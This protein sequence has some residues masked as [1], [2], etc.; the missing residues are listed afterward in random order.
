MGFFNSFQF[1]TQEFNQGSDSFWAK[2]DQK[3]DTVPLVKVEYIATD[4]TIY[5]LSR[6]YDSG[7]VVDR[8]KERAPAEIQ[9]GDFDVTLFNHDDYF[10]EFVP[11]SLL[12]NATYHGSQI[13]VSLGFLLD[14]GSTY[15]VPQMT[16]LIDALITSD[17]ESKVTF[18]CRDLVQRILDT[19]LHPRQLLE[20]PVAGNN[21]GNGTCSAVESKPFKT[22]NESWTL[23][24]TTGG[25][26]GIAIFS[27]VG[28]VSGALSSLTSGTQY[29]TLAA[30]GGIR[31]LVS[32]GATA[33]A[34]G[35]SF[36]FSTY[37]HPEWSAVNIGK[38]IW[39]V[40]TGYNWDT[41]TQE[42]WANSV[43]GLDHTQGDANPD[44]NYASFALA[45]SQIPDSVTGYIDYEEDTVEF[46]K[47][48]LLMFL[49]SI[50]TDADGKLFV[51]MYQPQWQVSQ[52]SYSDAKKITRLGYQR[53]IDE[54]INY[55]NIHFKASNVWEFTNDEINY[56]GIF[57]DLDSGSIAKYGQL[58]F[59]Y[60]LRWYESG[61]SHVAT[62]VLQLLTK[63][64]EPPLDI[65]LT[66]GLDG[67]VTQLGDII[68]VTDTKYNLSGVLAE[69]T[70]LTKDLDAGP[71]EVR[72]R[73]VRD[74]TI[75]LMYG[76]LG[77]SVDEGDGISPQ[78]ATYGSATDVDKA[79]CYLGP[80]SDA[81]PNYY[82]F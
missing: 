60:S 72:I 47:G 7:A 39:A 58:P 56:D 50:F 59:T 52:R 23:T 1:N 15:Y 11:S 8:I 65:D 70:R 4:G 63:Y 45:I 30:A 31:L 10:S 61:N 81:A 6:Y 62:V 54:V 18:R 29:S 36:T 40:L 69:V 17:V 37:Q 77:S 51:K 74:A 66:T 33:W 80:D 71:K 46:L 57:I 12:Y 64:N 68:Q 35:D 53:N 14:D 3:Q 5:D 49:G 38:I 48:L 22:K 78:A 32:A 44:I 42:V 20:D 16:G 21:H 73:A 76:F 9:A 19:K 82:M 43:L 55:I 79:F 28:S 2:L 26:D 25:L 13:R 27:V 24:C 34:A 67:I 41:N 75:G